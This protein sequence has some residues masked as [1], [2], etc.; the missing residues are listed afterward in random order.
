WWRC[1]AGSRP[2]CRRSGCCSR[3]SASASGWGA[4]SRTRASAPRSIS[5]PCARSP[6]RSTPRTWPSG[7]RRRATSPRT[8]A[9]SPATRTARARR[10]PPVA[11]G[12]DVAATAGR[13]DGHSGHRRD[14]ARRQHRRRRGH[15]ARSAAGARRAAAH[16]PAARVEPLPHAG[17]G[18]H[19]AGRFHQ[20]GRPA[21]DRA[22]CAGAAG[23]A[24]RGRAALRPRPRRVAAVG[25]AHAGPRPAAVRRRRDRRTGAAGAAS[26][27]A[28]ARLRTGATGAGRARPAGSRAG[29]GIHIA[30]R[31]GCARL[32]TIG[33]R[34]LTEDETVTA[35]RKPWTVPMLAEAKQAGRKLAMLTAYDAGFARA[36]DAAG[37][38]LVLVGD[39]LGMVVQ[40]RTSTLP[41]SVDDI[42][43]HTACV[44]RGLSTALLVADL[45]FQADA[46]P[47]RALDAATRFLQAGAA[48]AKLEGAGH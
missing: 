12:G 25:A 45:P 38:D 30:G 1:R 10:L 37:I 46:S 27:P 44:A 21:A 7:A 34:S 6:R 41:V 24:A 28:R 3:A 43:Y 14:R 29:A 32:R 22:R 16:T 40:G 39:S 20:R 17:L 26:A 13:A 47:Q 15:P 8:R 9:T 19:R 42:A 11:A 36:M 18:Q 35:E 2:R 4:C 31:G 48:M 23:R 33:R 5:W